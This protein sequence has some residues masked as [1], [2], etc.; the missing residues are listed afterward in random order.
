MVFLLL[1][2]YACMRS[3][4]V[5]FLI[6][7]SFIHVCVYIYTHTYIYIYIH[8]YMYIYIYLYMRRRPLRTDGF[9]VGFLNGFEGKLWGLNFR[10]QK[11][12]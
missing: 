10:G 3:D 9:L 2:R 5:F 8:L 4:L 6:A 7:C 1:A 12:S 11:L